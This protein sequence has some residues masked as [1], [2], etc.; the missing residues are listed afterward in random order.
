MPRCFPSASSSSSSSFS[1]WTMYTPRV[2]YPGKEIRNHDETWRMRGRKEETKEGGGGG[3]ERKPIVGW[4][5]AGAV[6][7]PDPLFKSRDLPGERA[8]MPYTRVLINSSLYVCLI[9]P[10][11]S[12]RPHSTP[13]NSLVH[14][15]SISHAMFQSNFVNL[16]IYTHRNF[17]IHASHTWRNN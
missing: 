17:P 15:I 7:S 3:I 2:R 9:P 11:L 8:C 5:I 1:E 13:V 16:F 4:Y 12:S 14:P 6:L 10:I